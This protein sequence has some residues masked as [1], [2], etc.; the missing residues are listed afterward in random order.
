MVKVL[1]RS[2][3]TCRYQTSG[4]CTHAPSLFRYPFVG[5]RY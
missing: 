5:T 2:C 3:R 4:T 1:K